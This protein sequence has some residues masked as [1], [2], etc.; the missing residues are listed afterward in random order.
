[1]PEFNVYYTI[2]HQYSETVLI[3]LCNTNDK[4]KDETN[5]VKLYGRN[6]ARIAS[7]S[8]MCKLTLTDECREAVLSLD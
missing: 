5:N 6:I 2:Q 1:M 8:N 3:L 7:F 4:E